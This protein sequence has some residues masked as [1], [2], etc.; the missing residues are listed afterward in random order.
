MAGKKSKAVDTVA[1]AQ[2]YPVKTLWCQPKLL[3]GKDCKETCRCDDGHEYAVKLNAPTK[4][5]AHNEWLCARLAQRSGVHCPPFNLVDRLDDAN[6]WFGSQWINGEIRDWWLKLSDFTGLE[7]IWSRIFAFDLFVNNVD[8]HLTNFLCLPENGNLKL[9]AIDHSRA[10]LFS[11]FPP[12]GVV[13]SPTS[14]TMAAHK[15]IRR[16]FN[17]VFDLDSANNTLDKL[18]QITSIEVKTIIE[19]HPK[20]WLTR[21]ARRN[22]VKWWD[23]KAPSR[24]LSI[25]KG[26]K[27][28]SLF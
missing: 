18:A 27:D 1:P 19:D 14:R 17:P 16:M 11:S 10:W 28:G 22:I 3:G 8:R 6:I 9:Y 2:L 13:M 24:V 5:A 7:E 4:E 21:N 26:L 15:D 23:D 20:L 25:K 12:S